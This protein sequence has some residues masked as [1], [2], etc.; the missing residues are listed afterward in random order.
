M[1]SVAGADWSFWILGERLG[2]VPASPNVP[3][4]KHPLPDRVR[5]AGGVG[6]ELLGVGWSRR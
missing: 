2:A 5:I 1:W 3:G 4:Q 6:W